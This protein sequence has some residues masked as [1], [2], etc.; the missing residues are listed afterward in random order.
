L[1]LSEILER[2]RELHGPWLAKHGEDFQQSLLTAAEIHGTVEPME[3]RDRQIGGSPLHNHITLHGEIDNESCIDH[4]RDTLSLI[5]LLRETNVQ[6]DFIQ[7][8]QPGSTDGSE[9]VMWASEEE[10]S[11][12]REDE[13]LRDWNQWFMLQPI[14]QPITNADPGDETDHND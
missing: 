1:Q 3:N 4:E 13:H 5:Q 12:R 9:A 6:V 10:I 2:C 14:P 7:T 8:D 11:E